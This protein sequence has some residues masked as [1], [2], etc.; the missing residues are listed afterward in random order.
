MTL[1]KTALAALMVGAVVAPQAVTPAHA[2][3]VKIDAGYRVD[4][5]ASNGAFDGVLVS[6]GRQTDLHFAHPYSVPGKMTISSLTDVWVGGSLVDWDKNTTTTRQQVGGANVVTHVTKSGDATITRTFTIDGAST[7]VETVV[8]GNPG[9]WVKVSSTSWINNLVSGYT[10]NYDQQKNSFHLTPVDPGHEVDVTFGQGTR[11]SAVAG[12]TQSIGE[13]L[14]TDRNGVVGEF[15]G[16]QNGSWRESLDS[17]GRLETSVRFDVTTPQDAADSDGDGLP[18]IWEEEGFTL[19]DGTVMDLPRWGADPQRPDVFLQLNWMPSEFEARGCTSQERF[20]ASALGA[21]K[22]EECDDANKEFY[23]PNSDMLKDLEELFDQH[24][25]NLHIDAGAL[26]ASRIGLEDRRGGPNEDVL[27]YSKFA[28]SNDPN[29]YAG[30]LRQWRKD[31]LGERG[32]VWH[33]GV[34]GD[35]IADRDDYVGTSGIGLKGESFFAA[36]GAGLDNAELNGTILHEFG[37][38]L[39]LSHDGAETPEREAY[40]PLMK[41]YPK[42]MQERN[43]I[44]EY[45]SAMNYLYQFS[46]L[47]LSEQ[48]TTA[49]KYDR[50]SDRFLYERCPEWVKKNENCF[51]GKSN[52]PAD[53]DNLVFR[54]N[55][56]GRAEGIVGLPDAEERVVREDMSVYELALAA[57]ESHNK[58]AGLTLND[59]AGNSIVVGRDDNEINVRVQ[60]KGF[61][62]HTFTVTAHW[63]NGQ[64]VSREIPL[65]GMPDKKNHIRDLALPLQNLDGVTGPNTPIELVVT[66]QSNERVFAEI[67]EI[68]VADYTQAEAKK[69]LAELPAANAD[70]DRKNHVEERLRPVAAP[71]ASA[72]QNSAAATKVAPR[73]KPAPE[74]VTETRGPVQEKPAE[75]GSSVSDGAIVSIVLA[76]AGAMAALFGWWYNNGGEFKLPF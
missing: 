69:V 68:P 41:T 13:T 71:N 16:V 74:P 35:R 53:W 15:A 58:E 10:A 23:R 43:R 30:Q 44:P 21:L 28:F 31:L 56:I 51:V 11:T 8:E 72:S 34:I 27:P 12:S 25:I 6:P 39:G 70:Q 32:A 54:S 59:E 46:N 14:S 60:N 64:E 33:V 65:P 26:Y 61:D 75:K 63:G 5:D 47:N 52:I 73:P 19:T 24:G 55:Y 9:T 17:T 2:D 48:P 40:K 7:E 66:N 38:V 45:R 50:T 62:A 20:E 1:K 49:G 18:D 22:F 29:E 36:K 3:I 4:Q 37:H 76:I 42:G 57:S 67:Y